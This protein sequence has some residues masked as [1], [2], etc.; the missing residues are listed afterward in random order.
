[1]EKKEDRR[2][3]MTKRLLKDAMIVL[4]R[5]KDIYH[6]S[7]RELCEAADV[8]RTTFYKHYGSQ[9]E[10]LADM[11]GDI[12]SFVN[13]TVAK[14][15]ASTEDILKH[16]CAYL[17]SNLEFARLII[18]N[19]IDPAFPQRIFSLEAVKAG[20]RKNCTRAYDTA[21]M[22]YLFH[23]I[24]YGAFH[25]ICLWLNKEERESPEKLAALLNRMMM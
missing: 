7:I 9:F 18:N 12:I 5:E 11:E 21:E 4:L 14:N 24:I 20:V 2:V 10:L 13:Q 3:Q 17:E 23:F 6:I 16:L 22:E 25:M 15:S 8:N 1:M 19:N